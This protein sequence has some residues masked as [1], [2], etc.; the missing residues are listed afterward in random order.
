MSAGITY[1]NIVS[2]L[3]D[4]GITEDS[5]FEGRAHAFDFGLLIDVPILKLILDSEKNLFRLPPNYSPYLNLSLGLANNN[6]TSGAIYYGSA[7]QGDPLPRFARVGIGLNIGLYNKAMEWN[8]LSFKWT[9]EKNDMLV[10]RDTSGGWAYQSGLGDIH[11]FKEVLQ[12]K[13]NEETAKMTGWELNIGEII[14]IYEGRFDEDVNHGNRKFSTTGW[15]LST[16]GIKKLFMNSNAQEI[17]NEVLR[18]IINNVDFRFIQSEIK[19][20]E[21]NHPL[22]G[23]IFTTVNLRISI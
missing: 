10:K 15:G 8:P 1:K 19:P 21:E 3:A 9:I 5:R 14:S 16:K 6:Y 7:S 4:F 22:T 13:I 23:I 20:D 2:R 18:F 12:G 17:T 11:F